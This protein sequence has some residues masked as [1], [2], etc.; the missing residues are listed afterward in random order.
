MEGAERWVMEGAKA[1]L[2][3]FKPTLLFECGLG[4]ADY[5]GTTP[6]QVCD[7]LKECGL[8][9]YRLG[10]WLHGREPLAREDFCR[11]FNEGRDYFWMA[12]R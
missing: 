10:A 9:V 11:R 1:S 5:Y 12:H 7:L 8:K 6:E 3:R 4:A 2:S